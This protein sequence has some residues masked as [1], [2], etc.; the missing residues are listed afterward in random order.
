MLWYI[1]LYLII[2]VYYSILGYIMISYTT[3]NHITLYEEFAEAVERAT[4]EARTKRATK[5][6]E[7][8]RLAED[9]SAGLREEM[10][11]LYAYTADLEARLSR[12]QD[13]LRHMDRGNDFHNPQ[14]SKD[15]VGWQ[16]PELNT[17]LQVP[18]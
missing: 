17:T 3:F 11:A 5:E 10:Q 15:H 9:D 8:L 7:A 18:T 13:L 1:I 6:H 14:A 12:G 16:P 2:L 4:E